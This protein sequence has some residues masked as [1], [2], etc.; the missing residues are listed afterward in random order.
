MAL[1]SDPRQPQRYSLLS[2][3]AMAGMDAARNLPAPVPAPQVPQ[4]GRVSGWRLL[5]RVLGGETVTGGLDAE[6][7]RLEQEAMRPQL[8]ARQAQLR[9]AAE[10]MGPAAMIAFETN[11][12]KFGE[13]LAEQYSPQVIAAGG[14]QSVI[15]NGQRVSAPRDM[16]FGDSLVRSDPLQPQPQTLMQRGPTFDEETKR[17]NAN[18]P[19]NVAA[20]GRAV[21]PRTGQVIA[22]GYIAPNVTNLAPGGEALVTD[23]QGNI[24]NRVA[25]SQARPMS[26]SDQAAV[27]TSEGTLANIRTATTRAQGILRQIDGGELNLGPMTNAISGARNSLG[28]SDQNSLNYDALMNWAREARDAILAANTGVQTDGDAVRAL[29]RIISSP[30]DERVVRQAVQRFIQANGATQEV[31]QRDIARRSGPQ[32]GAAPAAT[33][34]NAAPGGVSREAAMAEARRR[35]LIR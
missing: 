18:N 27:R 31:L 21:N 15:G 24:T 23:A 2:P 10:Q 35:G 22:E 19:I 29:E 26:D 34:A 8:L 14:I 30:Q 11:P 20:G 28:R 16:E 6:R 9:S 3:G 13:S 33:T 17:I 25:S 4:R 1:L 12:A 7:A 5:D 32:S